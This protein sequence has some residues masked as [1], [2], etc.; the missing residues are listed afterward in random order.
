MHHLEFWNL[1][2]SIMY[3]IGRFC[4]LKQA[5]CAR[6]YAVKSFASGVSTFYDSQSGS[7]ITKP[8]SSGVRIHDS[9]FKHTNK[10]TDGSSQVSDKAIVD[11]IREA[12]G[13]GRVT[14]VSLP[15]IQS[16]DAFRQYMNMSIPYL[17]RNKQKLNVKVAAQLRSGSQFDI[18]IDILKQNPQAKDVLETEIDILIAK[19]LSL[20]NGSHI[21]N[22]DL[23]TSSASLATQGVVTRANVYFNI[24]AFVHNRGSEMLGVIEV[25]EVFARLCDVGVKVINI[26]LCSANGV[27]IQGTM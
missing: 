24:D 12:S 5:T 21:T 1:L 4:A 3:R 14:S 27:N 18:L 2:T 6:V 13:G 25:G 15:N 9:Q 22:T 10:V 17:I 26:C 16:D 23:I 11:Y 19:N 7:F 20:N 8:G